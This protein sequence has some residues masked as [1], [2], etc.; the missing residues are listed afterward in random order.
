MTKDR[1]TENA[2]SPDPE[3]SSHIPIRALYSPSDLED[4][5]SRTGSRLSWRIP[6][7]AG[8]PGD[9]VSRPALDYAPVRGHG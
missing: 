9:D 8:H 1:K 4:S 2:T 5:E 7:Y 6:I 3:T